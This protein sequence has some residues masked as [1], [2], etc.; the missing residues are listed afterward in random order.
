MLNL[1]VEFRFQLFNMNTLLE[2]KIRPSMFDHFKLGDITIFST[3]PRTVK[4]LKK[5]GNSCHVRSYFQLKI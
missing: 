4:M 2:L 5:H 1:F 3:I